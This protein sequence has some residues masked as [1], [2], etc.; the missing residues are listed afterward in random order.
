MMKYLLLFLCLFIVYPAFVYS[1]SE[2]C[3]NGYLP[4]KKGV[5]FELTSYNR[6][7]KVGSVVRHEIVDVTSVDGGFRA[8][9]NMQLF[10]DKGSPGYGGQY[11]IDCHGDAL[12][13]DMSSMLNPETFAAFSSMQVDV[14]GDGLS[15]PKTLTAGQTLP[16]GQMDL[17]ASLNGM[18][19]IHLTLS[20]TD[21]KVLSTESV[22]TPA[23]TFNCVK[24]AQTSSISGLGS[25]SYSGVTWLAKGVGT[26]RTENYDKKGELESYIELT[27]FSKN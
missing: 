24:L 8:T 7:G 21:R 11:Y 2:L 1:Q 15:I 27:K 22:T 23:G 13:I 14:T 26:V 5:S 16:D 20:V 17:H 19:L 3:E 25:R 18:S 6:K 9:V 4:F 10:D 12:A